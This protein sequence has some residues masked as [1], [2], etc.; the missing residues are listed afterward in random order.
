MIFCSKCSSDKPMVAGLRNNFKIGYITV[1]KLIVFQCKA[2]GNDTPL[3]VD[4]ES[5]INIA[6][7][8][9]ELKAFVTH[10]GTEWR[11]II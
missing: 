5:F 2:C 11:V 7:E 9:R 6:K 8:T 10:D 4:I 1:S 3:I